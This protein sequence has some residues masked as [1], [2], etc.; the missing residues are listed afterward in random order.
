MAQY[1]KDWQPQALVVGVPYH[2]DGQAHEQTR[3]AQNLI[4]IMRSTFKLPIFE[5]DERFSTTQVK[6]WV[7]ESSL[8]GSQRAKVKVDALSAC[9]ILNQYFESLKS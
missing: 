3:F 4:K 1:I 9:I 8:T 6:S 7:A 5:V 2:P